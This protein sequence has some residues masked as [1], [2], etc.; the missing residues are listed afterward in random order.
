M[1]SA[2]QDFQIVM[3]ARKL[4]E[5]YDLP[6]TIYLPEGVFIEAKGVENNQVVYTIINDTETSI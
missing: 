5:L 3:D 1:I 6:H 2:E 4:A